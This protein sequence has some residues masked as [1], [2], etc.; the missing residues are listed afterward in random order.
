MLSE[1]I[2]LINCSEFSFAKELEILHEFLKQ[3]HNDVDRISVALYDEQTDYLKTFSFSATD[4]EPLAHYQF[5]LSD[6]NSLS[7]IVENKEPRLIKDFSAL[8]GVERRHSQNLI[9]NKYT[10]SYTVPMFFRDRFYGFVFFNSRFS[11]AFTDRVLSDLK[12]VAHLITLIISQDSLAHQLLQATLKSVLEVAGKRD[13]ETGQHLERVA[14]YSRLIAQDQVDHLNWTDE[15]V[16]SVFQFAPIHDIGK[17]AIPDSVLLKTDILTESEYEQ[18]KQHVFEGHQLI[19]RLLKHHGLKSI[20]GVEKLENIV[21]YHHEKIDGS[22]YLAG[23]EGVEIP[24]EARIVAVADIFDALTSSRPYK[25]AWSNEKAFEELFL[26]VDDSKLDRAFV[27]S[28][29]RQQFA[30]EEIQTI[31]NEEMIG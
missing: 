28:L 26:L 3:R 1:E 14:H 30:V 11:N 6:S 15:D 18:M 20:R 25:K 12:M 5:K 8:N 23:L 29:Y 9:K 7:E 17:L 2:E 24:A 10:T 4:E 13:F 27:E 22:G 21:L 19:G 16:E 31:F